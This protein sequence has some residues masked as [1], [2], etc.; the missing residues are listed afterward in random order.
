MSFG[1]RRTTFSVPDISI[2]TFNRYTYAGTSSSEALQMPQR[3]SEGLPAPRPSSGA[4]LTRSGSQGISTA[5]ELSSYSH[6][7]IG[8]ANEMEIKIGQYDP[9]KYPPDKA[10]Q[11]Y[12]ADFFRIF[13]EAVRKGIDSNYILPQ[14]KEPQDKE[15][16][17]AH[18]NACL[19]DYKA[20]IKLLEY[21]DAAEKKARAE[22]A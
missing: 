9:G 22:I 17:K 13:E 21:S 5:S 20:L 12:M 16:K 3:R 2:T 4:R 1:Q 14:R 11:M 15:A 19:T 8:F 10:S 7:I 6:I 18:L